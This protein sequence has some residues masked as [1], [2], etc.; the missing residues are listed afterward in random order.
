MEFKRM[1]NLLESCENDVLIE[2]GIKDKL[3]STYNKFKQKIDTDNFSIKKLK[4]SI[5]IEQ[6][7][8]SQFSKENSNY[9]KVQEFNTNEKP[10]FISKAKQ[11][12]FI[13]DNING[14]DVLY[15]PTVSI[16]SLNKDHPEIYLSNFV[17]ILYE[18][19][20]NI[21][22]FLYGLKNKTLVEDESLYKSLIKKFE[23]G[24]GK[25]IFNQ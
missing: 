7:F 23:K 8:I 6:D 20:E 12:G 17:I 5:D 18:K 14:N 19:D 21:T 10:N 16:E 24:F 11:Y 9:G 13:Y 25:G 3:V 1:I 4:F 15:L 22:K 2:E